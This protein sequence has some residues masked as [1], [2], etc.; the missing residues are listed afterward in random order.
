MA[1]E[2]SNRTWR[3][4]LSDGAK[5]RQVVGVPAADLLKLCEAVKK[6]KQRFGISQRIR[7]PAMKEHDTSRPKCQGRGDCGELILF[8]HIAAY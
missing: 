6:A 8:M 5:R 1:L 3:L 7:S 4:A 2:L